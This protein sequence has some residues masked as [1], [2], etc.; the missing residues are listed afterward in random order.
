MFD[1]LSFFPLKYYVLCKEM[2]LG[3]LLGWGLIYICY[4][5]LCIV[6][7]CGFYVCLAIRKTDLG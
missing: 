3:F 7:I 4:D 5:L 2:G 1:L 6:C